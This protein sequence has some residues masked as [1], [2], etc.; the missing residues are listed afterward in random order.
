MNIAIS[1]PLPVQLGTISY[2]QSTGNN[3]SAQL[4]SSA[5]FTGTTE[6]GLNH[7][8]LIISVRCDQP[9]TMT[10]KQYSDLAGTIAYP[11]IV[12]TRLANQGYND[13][14][15][16]AGSYYKVVLQNTGGATTTTLFLETWLGILP[17]ATNNTNFGNTPMALNEV[18]GTA[19]TLGAKTSAL[20]IPTVLAS[21]TATGTI[22]TQNLVP[23][24]TATAGSAV[25]ITVNS[26]AT[27]N[28]QVTGTYT[29]V[30]S[31][32]YTTDGS[33]W[34]TSSVNC[35][36]SVSGGLST[37]ISSAAVGVFSMPTQGCL[38]V[39]ITGLAAMTGTATITMKS[40]VSPSILSLDT[41]NTLIVAGPNA[42]SSALSGG[43]CL[44]G[45]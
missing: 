35:I 18:A 11:D 34:V 16:L 32:Q 31:L 19:L 33:T 6:S 8:N 39:R 28:V 22:T 30:L 29:G 3:T 15:T 10:I 5:T 42:H 17:V 27:V 12:Y 41:Q 45:R 43:G 21:D 13:S 9:F 38:K 1:N 26:S 14:I 24:G 40:I 2:V 23:V 4:A 36:R 37:T 44:Y 20:S 25:E 7:P